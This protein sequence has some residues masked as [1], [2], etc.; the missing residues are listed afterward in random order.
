MCIYM[1]WLASFSLLS[2]V[3]SVWVTLCRQDHGVG[4]TNQ[5]YWL[6]VKALPVSR[7]LFPRTRG[8]TM[9]VLLV[10]SIL[11]GLVVFLDFTLKDFGICVL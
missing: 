6:Y 5:H 4:K 3:E 1:V 7:C 11:V 2:S 10:N 8:L 9:S